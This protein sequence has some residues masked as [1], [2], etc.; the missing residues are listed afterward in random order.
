[1]ESL[2]GNGMFKLKSVKNLNIFANKLAVSFMLKLKE[3][4][5]G[6]FWSV[7]IGMVAAFSNHK[8]INQSFT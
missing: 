3:K 2:L 4:F 8:S 6:G 5:F 7:E 1:M